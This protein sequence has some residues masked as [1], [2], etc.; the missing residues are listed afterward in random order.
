MSTL[1][2]I[3]A[4]S[5]SKRLLGK[6]MMEIEG[7]TLIE[8]AIKCAED[9][10]VVDRIVLS[11]DSKSIR[12]EYGKYAPFLR[13]SKLAQDNTPMIDVVLDTITWL[14]NRGEEY[15]T[16]VL[17]QPTSPLRRP[18]HIRWALKRLEEG[19]SLASVCEVKFLR[20]KA[21]KE[22]K[23]AP[24]ALNG[25][26]FIART[27]WL[28][29][30]KKFVNKNTLKYWMDNKYCVD[31]DTMEDYLM[32]QALYPHVLEEERKLGLDMVGAFNG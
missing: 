18:R 15:D 10:G 4:R 31:I 1:C 12:N 13:S 29:K 25:A 21:W 8:L 30:H 17:L 14:S 11:T 24:M 27:K 3:P 26:I 19:D 9:S 16:V 22:I 20:D 28:L 32:A 7:K 6:N 5:G 23:Q 2:I